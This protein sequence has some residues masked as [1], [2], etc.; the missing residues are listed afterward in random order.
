LHYAPELEDKWLFSILLQRLEA[1]LDELATFFGFPLRGRLVVFLFPSHQELS[2]VF[3]EPTSGRA[4]PEENVVLIADDTDLLR[5]A[6]HEV[7]HL[8]SYRLNRKPHALLNE[9]LCTWLEGPNRVSIDMAARR[10]LRNHDL[11]LCS[12]LKDR[13]FYRW[14]DRFHHYQMAASFTAFL[15]R[16]FGWE[17][18]RKFFRR[19]DG[20]FKKRFRKAYGIGLDQADSQWRKSLGTSTILAKVPA[21]HPFPEKTDPRR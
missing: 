8:F 18:Y 17:T 6:R 3:A 2:A 21:G 9:G 12:L 19:A 16:R 13:N 1:I 7:A 20:S 15:I 14:P 11:T 4:L 5:V 10:F